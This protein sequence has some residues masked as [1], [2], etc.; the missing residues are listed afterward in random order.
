M[1]NSQELIRS[2]ALKLPVLEQ[3]AKHSHLMGNKYDL[4]ESLKNDM[5]L[6]NKNKFISDNFINK[7]RLF[8]RLRIVINRMEYL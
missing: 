2:L 7:E 5:K 6:I 3:M 4:L 1:N 8:E